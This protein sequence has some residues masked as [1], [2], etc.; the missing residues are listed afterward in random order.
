MNLLA[1]KV[2]YKKS[3]RKILCKKSPNYDQCIDEL[4]R[5]D[6]ELYTF[7]IIGKTYDT[8]YNYIVRCKKPFTEIFR[9]KFLGHLHIQQE[10]SGTCIEKYSLRIH[11]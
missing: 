9:R 10:I 2:K 11:T 1:Q 4:H 5:C 8:S 6:W 3:E 7:H